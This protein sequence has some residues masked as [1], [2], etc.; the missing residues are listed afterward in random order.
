MFPQSWP[1]VLIANNAKGAKIVKQNEARERVTDPRVAS[2]TP[3]HF[4]TYP[5]FA[6]FAIKKLPSRALRVSV[7]K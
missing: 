5:L 4:A 6:P 3:N 7:V 2:N 1:S